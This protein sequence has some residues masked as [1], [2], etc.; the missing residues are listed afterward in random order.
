MA[1]RRVENSYDVV[2]L[3]M[4]LS[5]LLELLSTTLFI[6]SLCSIVVPLLN[7]CFQGVMRHMARTRWLSSVLA[8]DLYLRLLCGI[9][10]IYPPQVGRERKGHADA[11]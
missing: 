6:R 2:P 11:S 3:S 9:V 10:N 1:E 7:N 4:L 8:D 5:M